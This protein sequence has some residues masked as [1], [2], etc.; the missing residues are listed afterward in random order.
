MKYREFGKTGKKLSIVGM[1][2]MRFETA[3]DIEKSA[4]LVKYAYDRGINYFDTAPYYCKDHSED[5][6][7]MGLKDLP[8]DSY[9]I[10]TKCGQADPKAMRESIERSLRRLFVDYIDCFHIWCIMTLDGWRKM[11]NSGAV[12]EA[13][14]A[15]EQGLIKHLFVSV[16]LRGEELAEVFN[17]IP[18][19]GVTLGYCAINYPYRLRS[20]EIAAQHGVGVVTMNPL[21]GGIIPA[22]PDKFAFLKNP[23]DDNVVDAA[24]RFNIST[25]GVNVALVGFSLKEHVDQAVAAAE[26]FA[27]LTR[28]QFDGIGKRL[29]EDF[30][31]IC[32]GCGYCMPCPAGV[33]ISMKTLGVATPK[34]DASAAALRNLLENQAGAHVCI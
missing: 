28:E 31:E 30:N 24:L 17:D 5:I 26:K 19:D 8:R 23:G 32:T 20:V 18:F 9:C 27:P 6:F 12:A 15:K 7:G 4:G 29:T 16:H 14:R 10:S 2:G 1:G 11:L 22:N 21:A 3:D 25:P 34:P 13:I 33:A